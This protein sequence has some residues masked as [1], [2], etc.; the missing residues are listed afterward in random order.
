MISISFSN[1]SPVVIFDS[2]TLSSLAFAPAMHALYRV[3]LC[4][5]HTPMNVVTSLPDLDSTQSSAVSI[6]N[7]DGLH[8][9]HR[10][11]LNRV[12]AR[13][14]ESGL[15]A[16]VMTFSPH[17]VQFLSPARAPKLISTLDQKI[18]LIEQTGVDL[19]FIVNFDAEFA[20]LSPEEF[21]NRYLIRG[22]KARSVCVGNNFNF[23]YRQR[24]RIANSA[25]RVGGIGISSLPAAGPLV[26]R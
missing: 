8:L 16:A 18:R 22:L 21:I 4:Y 26:R 2:F 5:I 7:F 6:G 11:I 23:G 25:T 1:L 3:S 13:A 17:P 9:G 24:G 14:R 15:R 20:R 19:L 12:V 10:T